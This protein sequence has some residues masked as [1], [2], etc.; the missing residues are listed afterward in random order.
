MEAVKLVRAGKVEN[1]VVSMGDAGALLANEKAVIDVPAPQLTVRSTVGAGDSFVGAITFALGSG[2]EVAE[3]FHFA[4][5]AGSAAVMT[6]GTEFCHREDVLQLYRQ[7]AEERNAIA[8]N[9]LISIMA[10]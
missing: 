2:I 4:V 9:R 10:T 6:P 7:G 3:A 5:A 8:D 1:I